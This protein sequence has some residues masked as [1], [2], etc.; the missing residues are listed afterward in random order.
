LVW[1]TEHF[2]C[3]L[4]GNKFLVR[5]DHSALTYLQNFADQNSRL[6]RWSIKLSEL[7]FVVGHRPGSK[8]GHVDALS[9]H[10]STIKHD[11]VLSKEIV[12]REQEKDAFCM[13]QTPGTYNSKRQFFLDADGILYKRRL[14]GKHQLL[15]P[16]TLVHD[17]MRLNY[18]PVYIAHSGIKLTYSLI[19]LRYWWPGM[20]KSI[21]FLIPGHQ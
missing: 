2:R 10:V 1:A 15:V 17:V 21:D 12:L 18:D 20:R 3:Y 6:L 14:D 13:K 7:D 16:Q 8:I 9:R 11:A 19:A 5:T 4:Y